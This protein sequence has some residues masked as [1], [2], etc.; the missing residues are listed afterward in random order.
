MRNPIYMTTK[1]LLNTF[2]VK[3][4]GIRVVSSDM[5][6]WLLND[7]DDTELEAARVL[8]RPVIIQTDVKPSGPS[9]QGIFG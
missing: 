3:R 7:P 8:K 4:N 5:V 9:F 2:G 1:E 6:A